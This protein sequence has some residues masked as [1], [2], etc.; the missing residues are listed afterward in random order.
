MKIHAHVATSRV[1]EVGDREGRKQTGKQRWGQEH[2]RTD[3]NFRKV[4][5]AGQQAAANESA[6][7]VVIRR[8]C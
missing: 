5:A 3:G 8:R 4:R 6:A 7:A 1:A 2:R